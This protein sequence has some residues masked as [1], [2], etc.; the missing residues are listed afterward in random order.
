MQHLFLESVEPEDE[1]PVISLHAY[2]SPVRHNSVFPII[3]LY[4][5]TNP[6]SLRLADENPDFS[7]VKATSKYTCL[8]G[9]LENVHDVTMLPS[10]V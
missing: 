5:I 8:S 10:Q 4:Y 9:L 2:V 6:E 1:T 7:I 3:L